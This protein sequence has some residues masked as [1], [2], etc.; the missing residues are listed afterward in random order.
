[1]FDNFLY[2]KLSMVH[3]HGKLTTF[4]ILGK[5]VHSV[6]TGANG[7]IVAGD[8]NGFVYILRPYGVDGSKL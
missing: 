6:A 7:H 5:F 2:T 8:T 3:N 1:M 4:P